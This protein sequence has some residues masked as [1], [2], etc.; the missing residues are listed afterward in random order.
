MSRQDVWK[1]VKRRCEAA[2]LPG[3]ICNHSFRATGITIHQQRGGDIQEAAKLASDAQDTP[4]EPMYRGVRAVIIVEIGV[5]LEA[6]RLRDE[7]VHRPAAFRDAPR[8]P[9]LTL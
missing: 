8:S 1:M 3:D 2:G 5:R 9:L 6:V 4:A 7:S